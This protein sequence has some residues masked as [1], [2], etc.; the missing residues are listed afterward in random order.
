MTPAAVTMVAILPLPDLDHIILYFGLL[1][2][3]VLALA[4]GHWLGRRHQARG[5]V[6]AKDWVGIVDGPILA[7]FGLLLA[8]SF[9][10]AMQRF[11]ERRKLIIEE[12]VALAS[13]YRHT[14]LLASGD[15]SVIQQLLRDYVEQQAQLRT[16]A[17]EGGDAGTLYGNSRQV[18]EKLW[19][20]TVAATSAPESRDARRAMLAALDQIDR[21]ST[22]SST[23][24]YLHPP[25]IIIAVLLLLSLVSAFLLGY[26]AST[27][28]RKSWVHLGLFVI[29]LAVVSYLI[30]DL[31]YPRVGVIRIGDMQ[32]FIRERHRAMEY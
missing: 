4:G 5:N 21:I 2:G 6:E 32:E 12:S 31:E 16:R 29:F 9:Y 19:D 23:S 18:F 24:P 17:V 27:I 13:A 25:F 15:R 8:F 28:A 10:G 1:A 14:D 30:V 22:I 11:D 20:A 3:M 7:I 26:Q